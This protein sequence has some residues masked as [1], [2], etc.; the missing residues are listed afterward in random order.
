MRR[1]ARFVGFATPFRAMSGG[2]DSLEGFLELDG[3]GD[4]R[5]GEEGMLSSPEESPPASAR[6]SASRSAIAQAVW[7]QTV[8]GFETRQVRRC[9]FTCDE[10]YRLGN[11]WQHQG[12]DRLWSRRELVISCSMVRGNK[13]EGSW[14]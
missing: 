6:S 7:W 3:E 4:L 5:L 12:S 9:A 13:E 10:K 11:K 2:G 14:N 8:K 1:L